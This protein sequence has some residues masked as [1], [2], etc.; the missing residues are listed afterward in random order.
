MPNSPIATWK[1]LIKSENSVTGS[2]CCCVAS[3]SVYL[4]G[5]IHILSVQNLKTDQ[6]RKKIEK[7][8]SKGIMSLNIILFDR[9]K[10]KFK[11]KPKRIM[12]KQ[13]YKG[14]LMSDCN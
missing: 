14:Q 9:H 8:A 1:I 10:F 12:G 13:G 5:K 4:C 7:L 6:W 11:N 3:M 2:F